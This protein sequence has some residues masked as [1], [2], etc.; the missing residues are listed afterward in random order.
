MSGGAGP[1]DVAA[2]AEAAVRYLQLPGNQLFSMLCDTAADADRRALPHRGRVKDFWQASLD[3]LVQKVAGQT[4]AASATVGVAASEVVTWA[5]DAGVDVA[6]YRVPLAILVALTV[7]S[8][9]EQLGAL[10]EQRSNR[11]DDPK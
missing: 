7:K 1:D 4:D 2:L 9:W 6:Q 10:G 11:D 8:V 3:R 5:Q